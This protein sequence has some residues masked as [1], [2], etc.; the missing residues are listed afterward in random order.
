MRLAEVK[1]GIMSVDDS[2]NLEAVYKRFKHYDYQ[3]VGYS[4]LWGKMIPLR[5][6]HVDILECTKSGDSYY[7]DGEKVDYANIVEIDDTLLYLNTK[8]TF[9][10]DLDKLFNY[11]YKGEVH[12]LRIMDMQNGEAIGCES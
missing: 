12:I 5:E 4:K 3:G 8:E 6:N 7:K 1:F 10:V 11:G 2:V 9:L